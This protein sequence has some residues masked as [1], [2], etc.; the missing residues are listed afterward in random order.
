MIGRRTW[1]LAIVAAAA[2]AT[3]TRARAQGRDPSMPVM[4]A[5]RAWAF[6]QASDRR[7]DYLPGD[8]IVKFRAGASVGERRRALRALRSGPDP[9][10]LDWITGDLAV[11]HDPTERDGTIL[12]AQLRGQPEVVYAEP[13]YIGRASL[14]PSDPGFHERQWN[15]SA[16]DMPRAWDIAGGGSSDLIVA[17]VD[18]GVTTVNQTLEVATWD[19][20]AIRPLSVPVG[21]S[22]DLS[23]SRF[24][25]PADFANGD[26]ATPIVVDTAG[27]GTHVASTLAENTNNALG[28][29]GVA[30][31]VKIM[32]VKVCASYWDMQF[33]MSRAGIPGNPN[34]TK[35]GGECRYTVADVARAI[36]YAV[37]N[38]ARVLNLSLIGTGKSA[39]ELDALKYAVS[40]GAFIAISAGNNFETGNPPQYPASFAAD[41]DG[42][43]AV[44]SVGPTLARAEY[45]STG[46]YVEIAAPGGTF[47]DG[48]SGAIWQVTIRGADSFPFQ[49]T[50][51][52]FDRYAE[53]AFVGTSMASPHVAGLAA[54]LMS[55]GV[56][57]PAAIEALIRRTA[58]HLG[59][60]GRN[61][62]F[63]FGLVQPRAALLGLGLAR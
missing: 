45:S 56:T 18:S 2:A 32:P 13:N 6:V 38:G 62:E 36:V 33:A 1:V 7:L 4:S 41:L 12:A 46:P 61:D 29:A 31:N 27:H 44:A 57:D 25:S 59:T 39:A 9:S 49:I 24:V 50:F 30:Y 42:V 8:V 52:R 23:A 37:D 16:I 60:P 5:G 3:L 14:V 35:D 19:G 63:G 22:P 21:I 20:S 11:H 10:D 58:L 26:G 34:F 47:A 54:L 53:T 43:M 48:S 17:V 51:P 55:R 28:E 15:L 40:K